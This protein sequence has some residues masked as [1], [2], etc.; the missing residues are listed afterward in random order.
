[1]IRVLIWFVLLILFVP[2][3]FYLFSP[4]VEQNLGGRNDF[5]ERDLMLAFYREIASNA[6]HARRQTAPQVWVVTLIWSVI[7]SEM[8]WNYLK[9]PTPIRSYLV[10]V[11]FIV[12]LVMNRILLC[13]LQLVVLLLLVFTLEWDRDQ[14]KY[15]KTSIHLKLFWSV[16]VHACSLV[17]IFSC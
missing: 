2:V 8:R 1:M 15:K 11:C 12:L 3:R 17:L 14:L 9:Q 5:L 6:A 4:N 16:E 7:C 10:L 13:T